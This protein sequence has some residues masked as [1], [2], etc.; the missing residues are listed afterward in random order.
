MNLL[1]ILG[2]LALNFVISFWNA[3]AVGNA[4]VETK[5]SGGWPRFM[6][7]MGAIMSALGF[8]WCY[9]I[10]MTLV[11]VSAGKLTTESAIAVLNLGYVVIVPGVLFSGIMIMI[12]SWANAY[13]KR[14]VA[15]VGVAGYN[16]FANVY[17]TY[18]A[19]KGYPDALK[20]VLDYFS[21]AKSKDERQAALVILFLIVAIG[22]GVLTTWLIVSKTAAKDDPLPTL[23]YGT[24]MPYRS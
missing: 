2:L 5:H 7:W 14:T 6:A 16:T 19:I 13:R 15:N 9:L 20:H 10:I 4:W 24:A 8:T 3:K 17:N 12:D 11:A 1:L 23:P 18:N 22:G 21:K